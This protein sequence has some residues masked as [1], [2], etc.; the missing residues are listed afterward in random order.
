MVSWRLLIA[1]V[2][3]AL[4]VLFC[5]TEAQSIEKSLSSDSSSSWV[6]RQSFIRFFHVRFVI[7]YNREIEVYTKEPILVIEL[8]GTFTSEQP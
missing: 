3:R 2:V 4:P 6:G 5:S 1:S 7:M 8:L